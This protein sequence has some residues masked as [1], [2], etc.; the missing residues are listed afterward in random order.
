MQTI[1]RRT[2]L[3]QQTK[4][5][6]DNTAVKVKKYAGAFVLFAACIF[7]LLWMNAVEDVSLINKLLGTVLGI[8]SF[9]PLYRWLK[10][11][12]RPIP[13]LELISLHYFFIFCPPIFLAPVGFIGAMQSSVTEGDNLTNVMLL[14]IFGILSMFAGYYLVKFPRL[15]FLPKF[16]IDWDRAVKFFLIYL[17]I[18]AFG[19][20]LIPS[21]PSVLAKVGDI[22]FRVNGVVA[23]YAL[24]MC[25]YSGRLSLVQRKIFLVELFVFLVVCLAGGWLSIVIYPVV[26]F[27]LGE[28][29]IRKRLPLAKIL[30]GLIAILALQSAK[31]A[32]REEF[33]QGQIG[34][35]EPTSITEAYSRA[36]RWTEMAFSSV[37]SLQESA[38]ETALE[39]ANHLGFFGHV[40]QMTPER[41]PYLNGY[42][43][44][45]IPAMF[46]PRFLWPGKPSTM[47]ITDEI[48]VRYGWLSPELS[49]KVAV[50][51]GIMDEAYMNFGI[52]GIFFI[53]FLFG[54]FI[55]GLH[56]NL[57][58]P[59]H[60]FGWQLALVGFIFSGGI[61]ITWTAQSYLGGLWQT[62]ATIA[63][64]YWPLRVKQS[65]KGLKIKI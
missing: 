28:I 7:I 34:G 27:L 60:G 52:I 45:A 65:R 9:L 55:K 10:L 47:E 21:L 48:A 64:L 58:N 26:G 4:R 33:W 3:N 50:S 56:Y 63:I 41:I 43:Y 24:S 14:I 12:E 6:R 23:T 13:Y 22:V 30:F 37:T 16:H 53:M 62:I 15:K 61:M 36:S 11:H 20:I 54:V 57:A 2:S 59:E 38:R 35:T 8:L 18:S 1:T 19:P 46:V 51:A 5:L 42:S 49:G 31:S 44:T 17:G 39:R 40:F 29:Q 25:M 32:F